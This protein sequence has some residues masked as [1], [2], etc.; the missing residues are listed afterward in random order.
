MKSTINR[1]KRWAFG[2]I[3]ASFENSKSLEQLPEVDSREICRVLIARPNHR[4]GNQL[5]L[6]PLIQTIENKFPHA[7]I[8][9]LVN[10]GLPR[11]IFKNYRCVDQIYSLPKKPFKNLS[12]YLK[13]SYSIISS[14]YDLAIVGEHKSNSSKIFLK[15]SRTKFKIFEPQGENALSDHKAKRVVDILRS[16]LDI[17]NKTYPELDIKLSDKE[18]Q[19]GKQIISDIFPSERPVIAIFTN[20]TGK[21]R[22][23]KEWWAEFCVQLESQ[24]PGVHILEILPKENR[25]QVNFKY[26]T[27]LSYDIRD[28]AA[29]IDNCAVFVGADSGVM[30]LASATSTPTFGLFNGNTNPM[31]FGPY[32]NHDRPYEVHKTSVD[33]IVNDISAVLN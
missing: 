4:L 25:S 7:K 1:F 28:M 16:F 15:L 32:G 30:H 8:D 22:L 5:L 24:F 33:Q 23:T 26:D 19:R 10:G 27:Y 11:V 13:T 31:A 18:I 20:A 6:S 29:V 14:R 17:K 9:L 21:K 12:E 3:T 2:L